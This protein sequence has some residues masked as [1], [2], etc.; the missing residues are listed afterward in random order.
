MTDPTIPVNTGGDS[1]SPY[2]NMSDNT[3]EP[4]GVFKDDEAFKDE[5]DELMSLAPSIASSVLTADGIHDV[6]GF[7]IVCLVILVGDMARGVFFPTMWPLVSELGGSTVALGFAV[8]SFSFGRI[9]VSPRFGRWS[10][11]YG[12]SKTLLFSCSILWVGTLLYAQAQNVG[13]VAFLIFAQIVMG[14]GSGTLGVTRAFVAEVTAQRSRTTYMAWITAVQYAGFTVTPFIG[15]LF[16]KL[17]QDKEYKFGYVNTRRLWQ[18]LD[19][20]FR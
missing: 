19:V 14:L 4:D 7:A 16:T 9:L 3:A 1:A 17:L 11:T 5:E 12:Y 8:A 15:S 6:N 20:T 18:S 13:S 2:V 10:V